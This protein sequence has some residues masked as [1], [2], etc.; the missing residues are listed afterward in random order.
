MPLARLRPDPEQELR[1]GD[2]EEVAGDPHVLGEDRVA[3]RVVAVAGSPAYE[4]L[5]GREPI[6][7]IENPTY[8]E[9]HCAEFVGPMNEAFIEV[10]EQYV[11]GNGDAESI[12]QGEDVQ[13]NNLMMIGC[14][15]DV[16]RTFVDE[17]KN[18]HS[19]R[20][21]IQGTSAMATAGSL[22]S[23]EG[24]RSSTNGGTRTEQLARM[25]DTSRPPRGE[26]QFSW[27]VQGLLGRGPEAHDRWS[28][29]CA[30]T[31]FVFYFYLVFDTKCPV[32]ISAQG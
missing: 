25:T 5:H 12:E 23:N 2:G 22:S 30:V 27:G 9:N 26:V 20:A 14:E 21:P 3:A 24:V 19:F 32:G 10:E 7:P 11:D 13:V 31:N 6:L 28:C 17:V 18:G 16:D 15:Y 4:R 8:N 1:V 29:F